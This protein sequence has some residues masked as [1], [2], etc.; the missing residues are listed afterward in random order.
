MFRLRQA[1]ALAG[2]TALEALRQPVCLLLILVSSTLTALL[3]FLILHR[4]GEDGKLVRDS[5]FALHAVFGVFVA[6][7]AAT[8]A[9][10]RELESGT[11]LVVLSKPVSR[12]CFFL[13]KFVGVVGVVGVFSLC[14]GLTTLLAE[15]VA[16]R[17]VNR[18]GVAGF[19]TDGQ[20]GALLIAVMVAAC[21]VGAVVNY[22]RQRP[23]GSVTTTALLGGLLLCVVLA[24]CFDRTGQ[25]APFATRL[26]WRLV[27]V[28]VLIT[29]GLVVMS[30]LA[31]TLSTVVGMVPT[32]ASCSAVFALGMMS[33][34]LFGLHATES[35]W[36][37]LLYSAVPNWQHFW[38][39]D[40]LNA[41][42]SIT[43]GYMGLAALYALVYASALLCLGTV[44]FRQKDV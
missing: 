21:V 32:L 27:P 18:D 13:S 33:D 24:S 16:E 42:G 38:V 30:S 29:L 43:G 19:V 10:S 11:A 31:M 37:G 35:L 2:L 26:D 6:G 41:G 22:K 8:T 34:Y 15:R 5:A 25:W 3:P 39:C 17:F 28:S 36:A 12:D 14:A 7:Y 20:T 23:F 9:L 40:Q 4:F 1:V 44:L